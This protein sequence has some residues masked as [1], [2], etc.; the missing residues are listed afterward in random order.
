MTAAEFEDNVRRGLTVEKLRA[1]VTD[2][3][4][5][6]DKELEQE[7]R[8][9]NDKVKLA[10]VSFIA[11]SF[12]VRRPRATPTSRPTSTRTRPT[13]R[14]PRSAR[15]ATCCSTSRRCARRW[16]CRGRH[17]D[18]LQQQHRAVHDARTGAR[19]P[20]PAEDRRQGR[21]GGE[22]EGRRRPQAGES[23]APIS[24]SWRR[25]TP[26]TKSSAKNGGDLDYFGR[27]RMVPEFDQ[28][29][30][31]MQPG[32]ISDLVKTQYGYHI[33]KLVDKK[34]AATRVAGGGAAAAERS[35]RLR[36]RAGASG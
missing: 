36:T 6:A 11:D 19:Q 31:A 4:A 8:R 26:R 25:S 16:S 32:Q 23:A 7:Y 27:G 1:S 18:G 29:V 2:W 35:A 3:L 10:V 14:F 34:N 20:H 15:S 5:V 9:R 30:F 13:S 22:G 17:R 21:R 28:A 24:P 12:R 33:I